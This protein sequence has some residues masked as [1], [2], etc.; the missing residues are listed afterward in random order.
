[1]KKA[2]IRVETDERSEKVGKKIRDAEL[3]K[4]PY[5]IVI[6]EREM[7]DRKLAVRKH[8]TGDAGS[9]TIEEFINN[10]STEIHER[11]SS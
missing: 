9:Q 1:M 7:T 11:N 3:A 10:L 6:G 4:V 2:R 5:M 8:G